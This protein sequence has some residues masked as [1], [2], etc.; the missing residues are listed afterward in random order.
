MEWFLS[1]NNSNEGWSK[2]YDGIDPGYLSAT[3]SFLEKFIKIIK[4]L[5]F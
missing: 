5:K 2:E 4:I 3:I 1:Y